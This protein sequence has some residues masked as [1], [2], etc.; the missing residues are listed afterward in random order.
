MTQERYLIRLL[1]TCICPIWLV[2]CGGGDSSAAETE[3]AAQTITTAGAQKSTRDSES[4]EESMSSS[5][6]A[7]FDDLPDASEVPDEEMGDLYFQI[8]TRITAKVRAVRN[9]K[10][11]QST[12]ELIVFARQQV[13]VLDQR[14]AALPDEKRSILFQNSIAQVNYAKTKYRKAVGRIGPDD[15]QYLKEFAAFASEPWPSLN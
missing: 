12:R 7:F 13:Q 14:A 15:P 6:V 9:E 4:H 5:T 10:A 8:L 1:F 3:G 11:A 2:A